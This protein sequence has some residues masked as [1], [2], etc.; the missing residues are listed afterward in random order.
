VFF[1]E[2]TASLSLV[3]V[4]RRAGVSVQTVIRRFGGREGLLAAAGSAELIA[5][6]DVYTWRLLRRG[7]GLIPRQTELALLELITS[8]TTTG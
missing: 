1:E 4:T 2:P 6:C 3:E 8:L 5:V 7:S